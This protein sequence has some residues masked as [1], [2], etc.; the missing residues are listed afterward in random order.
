MKR[1]EPE[2]DLK[3]DSLDELF[4]DVG[5]LFFEAHVELVEV[6]FH[7]LEDELQLVLDLHD[8]FEAD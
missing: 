3:D 1:V 4:R 2:R 8:F 7:V 6:E 5:S